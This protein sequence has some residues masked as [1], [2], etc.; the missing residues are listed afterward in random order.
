MTLNEAAKESRR[1]W[2]VLSHTNDAD[3]ATKLSTTTLEN[4]LGR[5]VR[6]DFAGVEVL[7]YSR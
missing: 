6:A 5:P 3:P 7:L 2:L 4:H 1:V